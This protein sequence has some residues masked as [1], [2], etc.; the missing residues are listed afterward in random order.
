MFSTFRNLTYYHSRRRPVQVSR[1]NF[2]S[3]KFKI[4]F[5][6][7]IVALQCCVSFCWITMCISYMYIHPLFSGLPS[8]L[9]HHRA[10]S[11]V[12]CAIQKVPCFIHSVNSVYMYVHMYTVCQT[13]SGNSSHRPFPSC[14]PYICSLCLCLYFCFANE[15]TCMIFLNSTYKWYLFIFLFDLLCCVWL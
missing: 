14:Y 6:W 9:G 8:H 11:R 15:F 10:F 3:K 4:N 1:N 5:Y 13:Q 2:I 12:L 7:S